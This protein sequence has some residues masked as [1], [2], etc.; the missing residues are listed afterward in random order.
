M[1]LK[2]LAEAAAIFYAIPFKQLISKSRKHIYTR[3]RHVCQWVAIDAGYSKSI[4]ARFW[5]LDRTAVHYGWKITANRS[6][7]NASDAAELRRFLRYL[8]KHIKQH[9]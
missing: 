1:K 4:V 6:E 7:T 5:N 2:Q 3:P 8:N 9:E